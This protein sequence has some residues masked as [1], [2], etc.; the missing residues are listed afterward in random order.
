MINATIHHLAGLHGALKDTEYQELVNISPYSLIMSIGLSENIEKILPSALYVVIHNHQT[1]PLLDKADFITP[2]PD[3]ADPLW[4][5]LVL[6]TVLQ[7]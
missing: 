1:S 4:L 2:G 6:I 7:A 3:G 5:P